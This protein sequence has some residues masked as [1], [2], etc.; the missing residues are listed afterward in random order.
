MPACECGCGE[1]T[2][3]GQFLPGHDQRLRTSL[4]A[5]VGGLLAL[6]TLVRAARAYSD[7]RTNH[8]LFT[9]TVRSVLS[10]TNNPCQ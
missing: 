9:Q 7:G 6:R 3:R 10:G 8:Q 4:E 5:E 2:S 1:D